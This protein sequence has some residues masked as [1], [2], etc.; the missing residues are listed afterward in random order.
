MRKVTIVGAG[1]VGASCALW[2]ALGRCAL[3]EPGGDGEFVGRF[4]AC[5][6]SAALGLRAE[7]PRGETASLR[8]TLRA[9]RSQDGALHLSR[10]KR[11]GHLAQRCR[12]TGS[13]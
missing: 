5:G 3:I 10:R 4:M 6:A 11:R 9:P 12:D 13:A 1:N 7:P 8:Q 2:L